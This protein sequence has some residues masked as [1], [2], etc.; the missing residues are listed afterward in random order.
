[1]AGLKA[2]GGQNSNLMCVLQSYT[3]S[4]QTA[5]VDD[6]RLLL[7]RSLRSSLVLCLYALASQQ[8]TRPGVLLEKAEMGSFNTFL[9]LLLHCEQAEENVHSEKVVRE[10]SPFRRICSTC[11]VGRDARLIGEK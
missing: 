4:P 9:T 2:G 5:R 8:L 10:T 11:G 6:E 1:M 3:C 7:G